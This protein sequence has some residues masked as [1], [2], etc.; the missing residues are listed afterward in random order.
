[1]SNGNHG[2]HS[3]GDRNLDLSLR[4]L[5][6]LH[7]PSKDDDDRFAQKVISKLSTA[8]SKGASADLDAVLRA[9]FADD[10]QDDAP[11]GGASG[12]GIGQDSN[13]S[14]SLAANDEDD[15]AAAA[16]ASHEEESAWEGT[17][18][19]D[20]STPPPEDR[21][22]PDMPRV[23]SSSLSGLGALAG[24]TRSGPPPSAAEASDGAARGDDSGR[25]DLRGLMQQ[26]EGP[27]PEADSGKIN[28]A[29]ATATKSAPASTAAVS[30]T[31]AAALSAPASKAASAAGPAAAKKSGTVMY[32]VVGGLAAAAA[33]AFYVSTRNKGETT[34]AN[35]D[36]QPAAS[37]A[38]KT[39]ED[40][41][42]LEPGGVAPPATA[43]MQAPASASANEP[44]PTVAVGGG[45]PAPGT[46]S[47]VGAP[48]ATGG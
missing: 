28:M 47:A 18:S 37:A 31:G 15:A 45:T 42:A 30:S 22:G 13:Q 29:A 39:N 17:M 6:D 36:K 3:A 38:A 21:S 12:R 10:V 46:K 44:A 4:R 24:L 14:A 11:F 2:N 34:A 9:P 48:A 26:A 43:T 7:A 19:E 41:K 5:A 20:Q 25:I 16:H 40:K 27:P 33:V 23:S 8:R 32:L 1:M 35:S